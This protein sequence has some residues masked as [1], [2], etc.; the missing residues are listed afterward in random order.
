MC[1]CLSER[2]RFQ[3]GGPGLSGLVGSCRIS[4]D[5]SWST[6]GCVSHLGCVL[7]DPPSGVVLCLP[8]MVARAPARL[9]CFGQCCMLDCVRVRSL[10]LAVG[11]SAAE[12]THDGEIQIDWGHLGGVPGVSALTRVPSPGC[13]NTSFLVFMSFASA[14]GGRRWFAR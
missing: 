10:A 9:R 8:A 2:W 7:R 4:S 12:W 1:M 3:V 5:A 13:R 11:A 6:S 14:T